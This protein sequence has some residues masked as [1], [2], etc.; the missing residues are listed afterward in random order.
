LRLTRA[1][2]EWTKT[3]VRFLYA[4]VTAEEV[5]AALQGVEDARA[6]LAALDATA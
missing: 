2:S 4:T 5:Q 3:A 6:E 1:Q